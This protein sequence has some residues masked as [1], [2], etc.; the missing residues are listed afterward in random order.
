MRVFCVPLSSPG[1]HPRGSK[2]SEQPPLKHMTR[3]QRLLLGSFDHRYLYADSPFVFQ[4]LSR[5]PQ[6]QTK[7]QEE[8]FRARLHL[9]SC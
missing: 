3:S 9:D 1:C 8:C 6:E 2:K 4:L 5:Q 7:K